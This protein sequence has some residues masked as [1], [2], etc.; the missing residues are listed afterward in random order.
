MKQVKDHMSYSMFYGNRTVK[1]ADM[2]DNYTQ[3]TVN[4]EE[5]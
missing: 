1:D 3:K 4:G 2:W 5:K